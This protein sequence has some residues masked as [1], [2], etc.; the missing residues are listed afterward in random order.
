LHTYDGLSFSR[1]SYVLLSNHFIGKKFN[2]YHLTSISENIS[3]AIESMDDRI[4]IFDGK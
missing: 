3:V 2:E 4:F 1:G